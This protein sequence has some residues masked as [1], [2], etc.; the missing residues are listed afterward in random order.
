MPV[1]AKLVTIIT[2]FAAQDSVTRALRSHGASGF[3]SVAVEGHGLH[4]TRHVGIVEAGNIAFT[5]VTTADTADKLL[6]WVETTLSKNHPTIA[7]M[8]DVVAA[9]GDHFK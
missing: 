4:G 7:Y 6:H 5:A 9:P 2:S 3:T 8:I 1:N